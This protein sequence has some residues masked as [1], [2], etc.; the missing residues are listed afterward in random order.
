LI[1]P[2][3]Y[4]QPISYTSIPFH[5]LL[6]IQDA[7]D[8]IDHQGKL[9]FDDWNIEKFEKGI[10]GASDFKYCDI[11]YRD[12][13]IAP[14]RNLD[15]TKPFLK[16]GEVGQHYAYEL[17]LS[18]PRYWGSRGAPLFWSYMARKF[19]HDKLPVSEESFREKYKNITADLHIPFGEDKHVFI[20]QFSA[21]GMS[22]GVV[23]GIFVKEAL[24]TLCYRLKKYD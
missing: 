9:L 2:N 10:L 5:Q 7:Y 6:C 11:K 16:F 24:N 4:F 22:S 1:D 17:F 21:G 20:A 19:S 14:L 8:I 15:E 12:A 13:L 18:P 3:T 23:G